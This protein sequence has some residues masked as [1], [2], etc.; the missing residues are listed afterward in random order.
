MI[1]LWLVQYMGEP[2]PCTKN[3]IILVQNLETGK[4]KKK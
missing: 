2:L 4:N 3:H 1:F